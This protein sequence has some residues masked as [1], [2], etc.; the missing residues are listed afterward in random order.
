V[1]PTAGVVDLP[2]NDGALTAQGQIGRA[3]V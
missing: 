3:H 2:L 1:L